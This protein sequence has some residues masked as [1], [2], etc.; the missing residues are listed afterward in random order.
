MSVVEAA[1]FGAPSIV[2]GGDTVGA[3]ALLSPAMR[4]LEEETALPGCLQMAL[5]TACP[6]EGDGDGGGQ[7]L[8]NL[9]KAVLAALDDAPGL[10]TLAKV[11][12]ERALG[13]SEAA[14]GKMLHDELEELQWSPH[15]RA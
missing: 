2:N 10:A 9:A 8:A 5:G 14:V 15:A 6:A 1:A 7:G 11:A 12:R 4:P 3:T 13:W